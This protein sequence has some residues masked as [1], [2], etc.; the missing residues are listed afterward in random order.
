MNLCVL[1]GYFP[2]LYKRLYYRVVAGQLFYLTVYKVNSAIPHMGYNRRTVLY[3]H[4][5]GGCSHTGELR[6]VYRL[7]IKRYICAHNSVFKRF[8]GV[9]HIHSVSV[10]A[11]NIL[12][13]MPYGKLTC[14]ISGISS[15]HA[16]AN[17][18]ENRVVGYF[19]GKVSVLIIGTHPS[20]VGFTEYLQCFH[21]PLP[22]F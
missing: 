9:G 14:N 6:V 10:G 2:A 22:V 21:P 3:K 1:G 15:P 13:N 5:D 19:T 12:R 8:F 20:S 16:V 18:R 11:D 7:I 17:H 4:C